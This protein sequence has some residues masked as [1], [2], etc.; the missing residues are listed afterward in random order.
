MTIDP[1]TCLPVF[2]PSYIPVPGPRG[3]MGPRGLMGPPSVGPVGPVGPPGP[4][5]TPSTSLPLMDGIATAG[6]S[7]AYSR[8]DHVHPSEAAI[9]N[10]KS[11][12]AAGDGVTNDVAA[13]NAFNTWARAQTGAVIL[14][15]PPGTYA[16]INSSAGGGSD[17]FVGVR[18]LTIYAYGATIP[19]M[20][21]TNGF[22]VN[23][24]SPITVWVPLSAQANAGSNSVS[25]SVA[26]PFNFQVGSWVAVSSLEMQGISGFPPNWYYVDYVRI[27]SISGA[28]VTFETAL[29]FTHKITYP[30]T[31]ASST[32]PG[33]LGGP[34]SM[35]ALVPEW[36]TSLK[37]FGLTV[38]AGLV[39]G[40]PSTE[41]IFTGRRMRFVDCSFICNIAPSSSMFS[42]FEH[43][44]F[45]SGGGAGYQVEVD[46]NLSHLRFYA[47]R[48]AVLNLQ[49]ASDEVVVDECQ[50]DNLSGSTKRLML[51]RTHVGSAFNL[52]APSVGA[53]RVM[54]IEG[55]NL[56]VVSNVSNINYI[57]LSN[58]TFSNGT[59]SIPLASSQLSYVYRFAIPGSKCFFNSNSWYNLGSPFII[60]NVYQ[61]STN[62]YFDTTLTSIPTFS[63][64]GTASPG[65]CQHPA[66]RLTASGNTGND[67]AIMLSKLS[68][69]TPFGSY[70]HKVYSEDLIQPGTAVV[71]QPVAQWGILT[72]LR[73]NVIRADTGPNGTLAMHPL[74]HF[75]A[76]VMLPTNVAGAF[77][78]TIDLKTAGVRTIT[79][80]TVTGNVGA[81]SITA[82]GLVWFMQNG[83]NPW[84]SASIATNTPVQMPIV[85]I[86]LVTDQGI[87][88]LEYT[89]Q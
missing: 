24:S 72:S 8:E 50:I 39:T 62:L 67:T 46:K 65:I 88:A 44:N 68:K 14:V 89:V 60:T 51:R 42:I 57:L 54:I 29:N 84:L 37:V 76:N 2:P 69:E 75:G 19:I 87:T 34:A 81:D 9:V 27:S 41:T 18:D 49:S 63:G 21:G 47:S 36:D 23:A 70:A 74:G 3:P 38:N 33:Q 48:I 30:N 71:T 25:L 86:E 52:T 7:L 64:T 45:S 79:P 1:D 32:Y 78:L 61:D 28:T 17:F 53:N 82:P 56:A 5:R 83:L 85:E 77:D 55:C 35:F 22:A 6:T 73:V 20:R 11:F 59:F 43:C 16:G 26:P 12:G 58:L 40:G 13:F 31:T 15:M 80:T 10:I 66:P 4:P